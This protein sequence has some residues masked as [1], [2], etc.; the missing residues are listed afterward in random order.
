MFW[1][2]GWTEITENTESLLR[3]DDDNDDVSDIYKRENI[4]GVD[5]LWKQ[6]IAAVCLY[7]T[8]LKDMD[9]QK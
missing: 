5:I 2:A 6:M 4:S 8:V 1:S 7:I 9:S 3:D